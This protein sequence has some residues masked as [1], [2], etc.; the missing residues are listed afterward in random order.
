[1]LAGID[2]RKELTEDGFQDRY[3]QLLIEKFLIIVD[4]GWIMRK[5]RFYRGAFQEEDER[6]GAR[7]L[8]TEMAGQAQWIGLRY[9]ALRIGVR[10]LPHGEDTASVQKVRQMAASLSD[11]DKGFKALRGKI[12]GSPDAG[13]A[14]RVRDYADK[15]INTKDRTKYLEL[16]NEIDK[17]YQAAALPVLL[18][19]NAARFSGALWLQKILRDAA[20]SYESENNAGNHFKVTAQLL[21]DLRDI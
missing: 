12:H 7:K 13:D 21:S 9:P 8:L 20:T 4:D 18:Q 19:E 10:L 14:R 1:M 6:D 11:Q 17:V 2:A 5:A 15:I 3:N 16:A